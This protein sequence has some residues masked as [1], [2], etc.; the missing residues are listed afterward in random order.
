MDSQ[1]QSSSADAGEAAKAQ[2]PYAWRPHPSSIIPN[3]VAECDYREAAKGI[4]PTMLHIPGTCSLRDCFCMSIH[5]HLLCIGTNYYC[6]I[7]I[8]FNNNH[9]YE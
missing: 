8:V 1:E 6:P 9:S 3:N 2:V 5:Q 7:T 4:V